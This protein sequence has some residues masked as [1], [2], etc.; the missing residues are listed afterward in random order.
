M[1]MF[2]ETSDEEDRRVR[3]LHLKFPIGLC[4]FCMLCHLTYQHSYM[5][6]QLNPS[7]LITVSSSSSLWSSLRPWYTS[8]QF[9]K[10]GTAF[11]FYAVYTKVWRSGQDSKRGKVRG[12]RVSQVVFGAEASLKRLASMAVGSILT[13]SILSEESKFNL[14]QTL[15]KGH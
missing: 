4:Y 5:P 13:Q 8:I 6:R 1:L 2:V 15:K 3:F 9:R 11:E 14:S 7:E 12:Q 10:N